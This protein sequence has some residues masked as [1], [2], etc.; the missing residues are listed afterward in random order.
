[1]NSLV[2]LVAV[3]LAYLFHTIPTR[4]K[5]NPTVS[6]GELDH[7]LLNDL[8]EGF[9]RRWGPFL[10]LISN[11]TQEQTNK[12]YEANQRFGLTLSDQQIVTGLEIFIIA[13]S[14]HCNMSTYHF[15]IIVALGWFSSTT[16][17][18]TLTIL[19]DYFRDAPNLRYTQ[20]LGI[21][22]VFVMLLI[23]LLVLY[24]GL[25]LSVRVQCRFHRIFIPK[26]P[27]LNTICMTLVLGY[28]VLITV[29]KC[30]GFCSNRQGPYSSIRRILLFFGRRGDHGL[31]SRKDYYVKRLRV[32]LVSQSSVVLRHVNTYF[33]TFN[34]VY[35][36]FLDSFLWEILWLFFNNIRGIQQTFWARVYVRHNDQIMHA[37]DENKWGFGQLL[38]LLLLV[39]P[40]VAAAAMLEARK[41]E[42]QCY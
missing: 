37:D 6:G 1:M 30:L 7:D 8:D 38:A 26:G 23:G 15:F 20:L 40:I 16:H 27:P 10:G 28:L 4:K 29:S 14:R 11:L 32:V 34:F 13:Y 39:L 41:T 24:T 9:L 17:L 21:L 3:A 5:I 22:E 25:P 2:A 19:N 31:R 42:R 18:S 35:S 33:L 12:Q 36:E